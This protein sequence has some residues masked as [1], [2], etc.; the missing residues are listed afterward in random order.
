[1]PTLPAAVLAEVRED[2]RL[3]IATGFASDK[4]IAE[5]VS[6]WAFQRVENEVPDYIGCTSTDLRQT[7]ER[8]T[9]EAAATHLRLQAT[10]PE[11]TDCDRLDAAFDALA[12]VGILAR[13]DYWE[14]GEG[15]Y[16]LR[17]ELAEERAA[18]RPARGYVYY[19]WEVT[20]DAVEG[21]G[22]HL[23]FGAD[24]HGDV[25]KKRIARE[26]V[27]A[28]A[29]HGLKPEWDGNPAR[30]VFVPMVWRRRR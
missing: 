21:R 18:G 3:L 5:R 30:C 6:E 8:L 29:A 22:L 27:T 1:M 24:E 25:A 11:V 16:H 15:H 9:A 20:E 12:S 7:A 10:W 14:F 23:S 26:V 28:L 4:V 2:I 19:P 13:H 17:E